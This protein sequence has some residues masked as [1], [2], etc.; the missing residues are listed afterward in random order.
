MPDNT[1]FISNSIEDSL[2]WAKEFATRLKPGD[3]IVLKG[4]LGVGKNL[5]CK[6]ICNQLGFEGDVTSPTYSIAQEY[7]G[8]KGII[9]LDFYRT[10]SAEEFNEIGLDHYFNGENICLIEWPE[11]NHGYQVDFSMT[12]TITETPSGGRLISVE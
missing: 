2:A 3:I 10:K 12:I 6:G 7:E 8:K 4:N 11:I 1:P 9:H 5:I